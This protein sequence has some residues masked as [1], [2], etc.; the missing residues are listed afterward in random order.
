MNETPIEEIPT[1]DHEETIGNDDTIDEE[2]K[3]NGMETPNQ[4]QGVINAEG[5][6]GVVVSGSQGLMTTSGQNV[7]FATPNQSFTQVYDSFTPTL[8]DC[9]VF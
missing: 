7:V 4:S 1:Y 2:E 9:N 8:N 3:Q 5:N 6:N